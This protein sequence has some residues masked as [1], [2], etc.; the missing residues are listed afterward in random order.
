MDTAKNRYIVLLAAMAAIAF[1]LAA[2]TVQH[3]HAQYGVS[4]NPTAGA[5]PEQLAECK[6]YNINRIECNEQTL[7]AAR[8]WA[9]THQNPNGSGTPMLSI[10]GSETLL[11]V[12]ALG[13]V[14]GGV[15]AA[16]FAKGRKTSPSSSPA[17]SS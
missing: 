1:A 10:G 7:L 15:A 8:K 3:S 12:S 6:Q 16:F 2:G 13:A 9:I 14:F 4:S 11:Y 5:T 17:T